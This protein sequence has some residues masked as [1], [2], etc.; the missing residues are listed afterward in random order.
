MLSKGACG[1]PIS[2]SQE[3]SATNPHAHPPALTHPFLILHIC[4]HICAAIG[5]MA[6]VSGVELWWHSAA[7]LHDFVGVTAAVL[8]GAVLFAVLDPLLPKLP[9]TDE[10]LDAE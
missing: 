9:E 2:H 5:V 4:P 7:Q 1:V 10:L 3:V 8:G 6:T